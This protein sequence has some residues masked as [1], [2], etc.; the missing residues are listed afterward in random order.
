LTRADVLPDLLAPGL[1]LV[2]CGSAAGTRSAQ[3]RQ[4]Y[5]G[6]GNKFWRTLAETRLTPR[7][8][9]PAEY[10]ML[11]SFGIGLTDVV[12]DQSGGD[13]QIDFRRASPDAL[14]A[15]LER[16]APR[17]LCFS[18]KRAAQTFLGRA[19]VDYGIQPETVAATRLFVAP[20]P[21]GAAN[22]SWDLSVWR[23]LARRVRS[24]A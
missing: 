14:R 18:S 16:F 9:A 24:G 6:R 15:K 8:L 5:A 1:A 3:L 2:I 22:A 17:W 21:S 4:Y 13:S 7:Q 12:K 19:K 10:P 11:L 23:A 20:S